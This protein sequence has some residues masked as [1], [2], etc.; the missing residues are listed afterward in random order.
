ME[1][2]KILSGVRKFALSM[3]TDIKDLLKNEWEGTIKTL[4]T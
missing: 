2:E 4:E 3:Q 1:K